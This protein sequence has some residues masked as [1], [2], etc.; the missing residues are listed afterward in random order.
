MRPVFPVVA[1]LAL[2]S[3]SSSNTSTP[4]D[5]SPAAKAKWNEYCAYRYNAACVSSLQCPTTTCIARASEEGPLIEFVDCQI[6]K[7]CD[8][9]DDDCVAAAGTTDAE[10]EAFT[11]RCM[12]ALSVSPPTQECAINWPEPVLCTIV[13][14]PLFRKEH[15]RAVDA[16]LTLPCDAL[17]TCVA[18]A[19]E[20]LDCT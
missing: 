16:C 3:C 9:N 7:A 10:R 13:A 14:Y 8:A 12:A 2:A 20:P 6:A 18:A 4:S 5:L 11:A 19:T 1:V 15:M 17:K